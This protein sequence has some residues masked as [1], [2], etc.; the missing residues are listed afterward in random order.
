MTAD[1]LKKDWEKPAVPTHPVTGF[2]LFGWPEWRAL[3]TRLGIP[4]LRTNGVTIVIPSDPDQIVRITH[5]YQ[6]VDMAHL[7]QQKLDTTTQYNIHYRT[8][9]P[10]ERTDR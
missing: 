5:D 1:E 4:V 9:R 7:D 8:A 3:C 6:G 2:E 10:P